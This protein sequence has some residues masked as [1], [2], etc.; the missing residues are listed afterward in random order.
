MLSYNPIEIEE[1]TM[2]INAIMQGM[3]SREEMPDLS[4]LKDKVYVNSFLTNMAK[5]M[6]VKNDLSDEY[7]FSYDMTSM[8]DGLGNN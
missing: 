2:D 5:G 4:Q 8:F 3:T 7:I 1:M 6:Q